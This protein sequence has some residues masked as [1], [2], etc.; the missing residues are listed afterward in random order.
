MKAIGILTLVVVSALLGAG[1]GVP[2]QD[3]YTHYNADIISALD[4]HQSSANGSNLNPPHGQPGHRC[5][6]KVG[7]PLDSKP[8]PQSSKLFNPASVSTTPAAI[9]NFAAP[10][11]N[12]DINANINKAAAAAL[13][14]DGLNPKH[15]QPGHRCDIAVGQPLNSKPP[16]S[17]LT[18]P[19]INT[20]TATPLLNPKHGQPGHRCDILVGQPLNSKPATAVAPAAVTPSGATP[21]LNPKHGQP[22]HRCDILVGQPLNSKP[23]ASP[24]TPLWTPP[25]T[26]LNLATGVAT[27]SSKS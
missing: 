8:S 14:A 16:A 9:S 17:T 7:Q 23:A 2:T 27:D 6:L 1:P 20:A 21:L 19:T 22:G 26:P 11:I 5:D 10:F 3:L 25:K 24:T 15:G 12:P 4:L 13:P 18:T